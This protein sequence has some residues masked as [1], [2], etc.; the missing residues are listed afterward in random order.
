MAEN[1]RTLCDEAR[2]YGNA[3]GERT[4]LCVQVFLPNI[5]PKIFALRAIY[6]E[7]LPSAPIA[8]GGDQSPHKIQAILE[9]GALFNAIVFGALDY[10]SAITTMRTTAQ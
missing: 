8:V 3:V 2:V 10:A 5:L 9:V 7:P 6:N 1:F 4:Q